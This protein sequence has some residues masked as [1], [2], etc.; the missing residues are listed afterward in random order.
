MKKVLIL[1]IALMLPVVIFGENYTSLWK[2]VAQAEEKDL[3]KSEYEVLQ[4]IVKK[5]ENGKDY[6]HLLKAELLGAQVM[7]EIAPDS[8]KPEMMRIKQRCEQTDDEVLKIVYQTVLYRISNR[9]SYLGLKDMRPELT[10]EL[11]QKLAQVKEDEYVPFVIKG[12]D[13]ELFG[14]DLLSIIGF[15]LDELKVLYNYYTKMGNRRAACI[16]ASREFRYS[17]VEKLD[18]LLS[19]Y[20][21]IPEAGELAISRYD[22]MYSAS[23]QEKITFIREALKKWGSWKA[24]GDIDL[25][26]SNEKDYK[27]LKTM[28]G[29]VV[30]EQTRQYQD[31]KDYE[32]FEDALTIPALPTGVYMLEFTSPS[33]IDPVRRLY[34]VT[35][36][37]VIGEPQNTDDDERYVVVSARTGQ[38]IAGAHLRIRNYRTY[39]YYDTY[40]GV[41]DE[42]GEYIFKMKNYSH[43]RRVVYAY[44]DTDKACPRCASASR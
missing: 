13:S 10:E 27:T 37:F 7:S 19:L 33:G 18:E 24:N 23:A 40:E 36:I 2:K 11:C 21:D 28:L 25:S 3:P 16:V 39:S 5:A 6:G 4:K 26:P 38:P 43:Q 1:L 34:F 41:T 30:N 32:F 17:T 8:L 31:K 14:R 15:E 44:T 12:S 29:K 9:Y 22:R 35:D 20:Q 42:K